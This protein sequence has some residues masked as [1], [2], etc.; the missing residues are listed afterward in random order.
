V[1]LPKDATLFVHIASASR[2]EAVFEDPDQFD[3][4]RLNRKQHLSLGKWKHFCI[5]APLA[6][7]EMRVGLEALTDR[8]PS[9]RLVLGHSIEYV[10]SIQVLPLIGGLVVD[11]DC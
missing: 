4:Y 9:M 7:M 1:T 6:R 5:G 2:D 3:L 11:W 8:I 10:P